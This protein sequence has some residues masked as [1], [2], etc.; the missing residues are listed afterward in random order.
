MNDHP[1]LII[2]I[3]AAVVA[4]GGGAWLAGLFFRRRKSRI[5]AE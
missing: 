4:F 2:G 3:V 1:M 5:T